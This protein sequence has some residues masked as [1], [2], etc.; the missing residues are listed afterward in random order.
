[1]KRVNVRLLLVLVTLAVVG[2]VGTY[3]LHRFQVSRNAGSLAKLARTKLEEGDRDEALSLLSRYVGYRRDDADAFAEFA[4]LLLDRADRPGATRTDLARAFAA[5]EEAVR[6]KP[7]D[8]V[9]RRR[10]AEFQLRIGRF[11]DA[12]EHLR[13]LRTAA[14]ENANGSLDADS[15][16]LLL[17]RSWA[18]SG[19]FDE[20]LGAAATLVGFDLQTKTFPDE[21][22][23]GQP[24]GDAGDDSPP[25]DVGAEA[26]DA[27]NGKQDRP[28]ATEAYILLAAIL[29][30][31]LGDKDVAKRVLDRMVVKNAEDP[32]AWLALAKWNRQNGDMEG[33]AQAVAQASSLAPDQLDTKLASFEILLAEKKFD[34]AAEVIQSALEAFPNDE[35]AIRGSAILTMQRGDLDRTVKILEEGLRK[36]GRQPALLLMLADV[37][38]QQNRLEDVEGTIAQI[39]EVLG[40][41][42]P[43]VGLLEARVLIARQKW[44]Q[45]EQKLDRV[46]PLV[47]ASQELTR[48]VDLYL[49]Q[50]HERLGQYDEQ[51][52]ANRRV[53][54][55]DPTSL[56]ARVGAAS[57]LVAAGKSDQGLAEFEL[58]AA[59]IPKERLAGIPQVWS[60]LLQLRIG[61]QAKKSP[62]DRDWTRVDEL[63]DLLGGSEMITD[64]QIAILRADLLVR[65]GEPKEALG[66]LSKSLASNKASIPLQSALATLALRQEGPEAARKIIEAA[67]EAVRKDAGFLLVEAQVASRTAGEKNGE[68]IATALAEIERRASEIG[69]ADESAKVL[70]GLAAIHYSVGQ[71]EDSQRLWKQVLETRPDD[72]RIRMALLDMA[73]EDGQLDAARA[74]ANDIAKLAGPTSPQGRYA[75]ATTRILDVRLGQQAVPSKDAKRP[76]LSPQEKANLREARN[77]LIEAENERPGWVEIQQAFA[78]I[79]GLEGDLPSAIERLQKAVR[80]GPSNPVVV[81]QLV[82]LLY[83]SN[84]FDEAQQVLAMIGPDGLPGFE[85]LS[86]EMELR[87]GKVDQA[88]V[89]AERSVAAD[90]SNP[91]ELLWLG[92]L[93][94]RSGK[95][96]RAEE[97]LARAVEAAP[98]RPETWL[99]LVGHQIATGKRAVAE[100][101]IARAGEALQGVERPLVLSQAYEMLGRV[102]EADRALQEAVGEHAD[103]LVALRALAAFQVRRGRLAPA[104]ETLQRIVD[105][106][107]T[108]GD[109]RTSKVWARRTL[110]ELTAE[111]GN[112]AMLQK[113]I[114]ILE[115]NADEGGQLGPE[116]RSIA[117][118]LLADRPEPASWRKALEFLTALSKT[119]PLS[120]SQRLAVAQLRERLGQWEDCRSELVSLVAAPEAPPTLFAMLVE[121]LIEHRELSSASTW[122]ATLREKAPD[123]PMTIALEAKLAMAEKDRPKAVAAAKKLM[124][125]GPVPLEQVPQLRS[126]GKLMEDLGFP[127]AADKVLQEFAARSIDGI[128]ARVEFLG[129]QKRPEEALDTLEAA[130]DRLPLERTLQ[131]AVIVVRSQSPEI[132]PELASRV[133]KWFVKARRLDPDSVVIGLLHAE[134]QEIMGRTEAVESMYRELLARENLAP[135]QRAVV[136]NNLAF[137]LAKKSTAQEALELVDSAINELG[138]HPDLLDTRGVV[139]LELGNVPRAIADLR[140]ASLVPSPVKLLHLAAAQAAGNQLEEAKRTLDEA[141]RLGL[142]P[143]ELQASDKRRLEQLDAVIGT[144]DQ[145]VSIRDR[146][147]ASSAS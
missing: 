13:V 37:M 90:S 7:G 57:A 58:V 121:R 135:T 112:Y 113:A 52:E 146:A 141:R 64:E 48:Q 132:P 31:K 44:L 38:L 98:D 17:A 143:P 91:G 68:G 122:L 63:M 14:S 110:A 126:T 73:K 144:G 50:C 105:A 18:G 134:L 100:R 82:A 97:V 128:V 5:V 86:A 55:D 35:R 70:S 39:K 71:R 120:I 133:E 29:D 139:E 108:E 123:A 4:G 25:A 12:R 127:K 42:N 78:E 51:L 84:R 109:D 28:R 19:N 124:P 137:H 21:E 23:A 74:A 27:G 60:P 85:K 53:L 3:A 32:Q 34:D 117:I 114:A 45:A 43:A 24:D 145:P 22:E 33:A 80:L 54:S 104:R 101:T 83:A 111:R 67:P 88:V 89:I 15:I 107:G 75:E 92:Q 102:D 79:D 125:S 66:L 129:R 119:Q 116:D 62:G 69:D 99:S 36:T 77:L 46:R 47:A 93:L 9:L 136:A 103:S 96:E 26:A 76:E 72:L 106:P 61:E 118:R 147:S 94:S 20:A 130:W 8:H 49:G 140:E 16:E 95:A 87:S 40:A 142:S 6:K 115:Q 30:E 59:S 41:S 2:L 65:K 11:A 1:M 56:A 131:T 10:L 138:P 81:R